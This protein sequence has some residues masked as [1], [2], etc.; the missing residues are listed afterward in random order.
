MKIKYTKQGDWTYVKF[1]DTK[2]RDFL[3][4]RI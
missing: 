3:N 2:F 1:L 4:C